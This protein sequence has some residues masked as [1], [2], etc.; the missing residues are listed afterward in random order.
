[1]I[2]LNLFQ[3]TSIQQDHIDIHYAKMQPVIQRI[4]HL[5]R[6]EHPVLV[7]KVDDEIRHIRVDAVYYL[8]CVDK[9]I[10]AYT[11]D[12]V[13]GLEQNL[14]YYEEALWAYGFV[15]ISKSNLVNI[16][17]IVSL[18]PEINMR[19]C[20]KFDNDE[21]LYINRTYKSSF[22]EYL[23]KMKGMYAGED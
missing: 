8:D 18:K 16:Y 5:V 13:Y 22:N 15:R 11:K 9:K 4:I 7:A 14:S 21:K 6:D 3:E 2:K 17:K 10:Y 20:I 1:M 23:H 12:H 19:V